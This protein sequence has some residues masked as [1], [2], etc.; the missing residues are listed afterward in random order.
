MRQLLEIATTEP[1]QAA[2]MIVSGLP[3]AR[4]LDGYQPNYDNPVEL[5]DSSYELQRT[6][7][8]TTPV[9]IRRLQ[10]RL[11]SLAVGNSASVLSTTGGCAEDVNADIPINVLVE[12]DLERH[13]VVAD[14]LGDDVIDEAR[15]CGQ[16]VKPRS[17]EYQNL[18]DR[19]KVY[20]HMGDGVNGKGTDQR[21][22]DPRR[23]VAAAVQSRDVAAGL[24]EALGYHSPKAHEALSL[25][26]EQ[27][28]MRID[29]ETGELYL[30]S[31]D[32]P[33]IGNRTNDINGLH[34]AMLS[35]MQNPVG[36]KIGPDSDASHIAG[37]NN[38]L[39]PDDIPGKLTYMVRVGDDIAT[40]R[41]ILPAIRD[42]APDSLIQYDLHKSTT[43]LDDGT[44]VRYTGN[45][46]RHA[47][48]LAEECGRVGLRLHGVHLETTPYPDHLECI[49]LP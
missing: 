44:K 11:T 15:I 38:V 22:P 10:S 7:P 14:A 9:D 49:E 3:D 8:V 6:T 13:Q 37:L 5:V 19:R 26:Y 40:M 42:S 47:Q 16:V 24:R 23:L 17:A 35:H 25:V 33:W 45:I 43:L 29:P 4:Y 21:R 18:T 48:M 46:I 30:L 36:V 39:N 32:K 28:F 27:S 31:T 34:V 2:E 41:R 12:R 1:R 20:S